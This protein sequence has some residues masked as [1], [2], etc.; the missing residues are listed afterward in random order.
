MPNAGLIANAAVNIHAP[1]SKVWE[2]L[3]NP[4]LIQQYFF[5]AEI[6]TDWK[7]GS[8]IIYKGVY[9]GKPYEDKG[10]VLTAE[11]EKLLLVTHWSPLSGTPDTPENYHQVRYELAPENGGTHVS[12]AQDNNASPEERDQSADFWKMVLEGMKKLLES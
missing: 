5:G 12:I 4:K 10:S 11:P 1:A 8:P 9:Q 2:A 6:I 3:T 7:E